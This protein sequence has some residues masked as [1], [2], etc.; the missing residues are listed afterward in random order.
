MSRCTSCS[1]NH[2]HFRK[3]KCN[4]IWTLECTGNSWCRFVKEFET[5]QI[6]DN[7]DDSCSPRAATHDMVFRDKVRYY[8]CNPHQI[9]AFCTAV[10]QALC[11]VYSRKIQALEISG[12]F[13]CSCRILLQHFMLRKFRRCPV[14][15]MYR[16]LRKWICT[17]IM[18]SLGFWRLWAH[19][20]LVI[21]LTLAAAGMVII[22]ALRG[23][24]ALGAEGRP[25]TALG[26]AVLS[27]Q[28]EMWRHQGHSSTYCS[29]I[30]GSR[31]CAG[32][33]WNLLKGLGLRAGSHPP[34]ALW[35]CSENKWQNISLAVLS[36]YYVTTYNSSFA[37][38]VKGRNLSA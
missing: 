32:Q 22:W 14:Y 3:S 5:F 19:L 26:P 13:G 28:E 31:H 35:L 12:T 21:V 7:S 37:A 2:L 17:S 16:T 10:Q 38:E 18:G 1:V 8:S 33:L 6:W 34:S 23:G 4:R 20:A 25:T 29:T 27:L 11:L 24:A 36:R 15:Q 9:Y 30:K